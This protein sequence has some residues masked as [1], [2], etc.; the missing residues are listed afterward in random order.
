M[1]RA[2]EPLANLLRT[3]IV[4]ALSKTALRLVST[5]V[6]LQRTNGAAIL[7]LSTKNKHGVHTMLHA[8]AVVLRRRQD[9]QLRRGSILSTMGD[10]SH[11]RQTT[12]QATIYTL[13]L[14]L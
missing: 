5:F 1:R 11:D 2:A 8:A 4:V 7:S 9:E 6:E 3:A 12:E 13:R 10:G 14:G